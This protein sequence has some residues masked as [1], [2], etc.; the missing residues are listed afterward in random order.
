[1][2]H[3]IGCDNCGV[4][5]TGWKGHQEKPYHAECLDC[6]KCRICGGTVSSESC[7]DVEEV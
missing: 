5:D 2:K 1:M 4:S 6:G 3:P 7:I